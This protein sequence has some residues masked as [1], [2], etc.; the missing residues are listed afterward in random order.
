M[1]HKPIEAV[2]EHRGMVFSGGPVDGPKAGVDGEGGEG[3]SPVDLALVSLATCSGS[4]VVLV[5]QKKRIDM[6]QFRIEVEAER[7]DEA[8][9]R[10]TKIKLI[11]HVTAP[12]ASEEAF[13]QAIDLSLEKYCSVSHSLNPDIPITYELRLQA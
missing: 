8:P 6:K 4:D 2:W 9:K 3:P 10:F 13:R 1:Q 7:R 12:G 5:V 11:Y